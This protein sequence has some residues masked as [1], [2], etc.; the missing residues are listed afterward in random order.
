M[1]SLTAHL[2]LSL[3]PISVHTVKKFLACSILNETLDLPPPKIISGL[4]IQENW[5]LRQRLQ[6]S[7]KKIRPRL[8]TSHCMSTT[9]WRKAGAFTSLIKFRNPPTTWETKYQVDS[10]SPV[11]LEKDQVP[12]W[13]EEGPESK[14]VIRSHSFPASAEREIEKDK[15]WR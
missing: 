12:S 4:L 8:S 6:K 3:I 15:M 2:V 10:V 13:R 1:A 5:N 14:L 11:L 7:G 9:S